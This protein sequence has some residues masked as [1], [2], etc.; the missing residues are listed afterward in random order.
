[1]RSWL[2][3]LV[4][5]WPV[6][7][8]Y[9][10]ATIVLVLIAVAF[11]LYDLYPIYRNQERLGE[12]VAQALNVGD[13]WPEADKR[14]RV[15]GFTTFKSTLPKSKPGHFDAVIRVREPILHGMYRDVISLCHLHQYRSRWHNIMAAVNYDSSDVVTTVAYSYRIGARTR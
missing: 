6:R 3:L 8:P 10:F 15:A 7:R 12:R 11:V 5:T 1:M 9:L 2:E 4:S 14:L 13:N